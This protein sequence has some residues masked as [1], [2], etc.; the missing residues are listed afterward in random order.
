MPEEAINIEEEYFPG[1]SDFIR[2]EINRFNIET[3]GISFGGEVAAY[4]REEGGK[5]V[6]GIYGFCWGET[7]RVETLWVREDQ[8]GRNYG[9]RLLQAAEDEGRRRG[10]K[11]VFLE[12]HSFQAPDFYKKQG[13]EVFG[14][15]DDY[16]AGHSQIF[17]KKR[18]D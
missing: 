12:T 17:F 16:P 18:L 9:T 10:C 2:E 15:L 7:L 14:V 11:Q 4:V 8:R 13:Y 3:T 1:D 5:I 6:A